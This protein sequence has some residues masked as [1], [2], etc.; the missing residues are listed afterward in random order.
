VISF[1]S[2]ESLI[3]L[4]LA[5][6]SF[7]MLFFPGYVQILGY[8]DSEMPEVFPARKSFISDRTRFLAGDGDH[9][10]TFLTLKG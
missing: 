1:T 6:N 7:E 10:L 3:K 4:Y 2:R 9:S 5:V 8:P